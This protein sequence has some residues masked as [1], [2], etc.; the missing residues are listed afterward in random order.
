MG[1][2]E[3]GQQV[4]DVGMKNSNSS[5]FTDSKKSHFIIEEINTYN[6][7]SGLWIAPMHGHPNIKVMG[8]NTSI[9][10]LQ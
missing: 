10:L 3:V 4:Q 8:S 6:L 2:K 7:V 5:I 9:G 1:M